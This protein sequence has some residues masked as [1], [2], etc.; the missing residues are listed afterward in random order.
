VTIAEPDQKIS[1]RGIW[2]KSS[3]RLENPRLDAIGA[4]WASTSLLAEELC[5]EQAALCGAI[6]VLTTPYFQSYLSDF[7]TYSFKY[8]YVG[9]IWED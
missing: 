4:K 9:E 7:D 8:L 5:S 1:S 3:K 2:V 6:R